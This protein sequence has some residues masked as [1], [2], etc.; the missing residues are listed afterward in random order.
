MNTYIFI[1]GGESFLDNA[2]YQHFITSTLVDWNSSAFLNWEE[3]KKWK[4]E[5]AKKLTETGNLVY[6]PNFPNESNAHYVEWKLF[7]ESWTECIEI[8]WTLTL[9]GHSLGGNFLLK[10]FSDISVIARND[11]FSVALRRTQ[12]I[13]DDEKTGNGLPRRHSRIQSDFSQ[14]Q[15]QIDAI[16]LVAAC[17]S[18]GD[19]TTPENYDILRSLGSKVHIWHAEDDTVVP[20]GTAKELETELPEA[21]THFFGS[22]KWY[23]HFFPLAVFPEFEDI[24]LQK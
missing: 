2:E 9:I 20:F 6:M 12:A 16:H 18:E 1:P 17:I 8:V 23:G 5:L 7:F 4:T 11:P 13:Q 3:Q 19:F 21:Q 24:L 22:E 15:I 10:Y 14:W